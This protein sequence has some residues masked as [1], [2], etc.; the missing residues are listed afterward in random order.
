M[1]FNFTQ[2]TDKKRRII[3]HKERKKTNERETFLL[4]L[5]STLKIVIFFTQ[6]NHYTHYAGYFSAGSTNA[7]ITH[8]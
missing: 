8:T 3:L 7:R 2:L 4:P 6:I 5:P 1:V